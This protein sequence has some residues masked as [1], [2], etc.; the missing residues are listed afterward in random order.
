MNFRSDYEKWDCPVFIIC[1]L[2]MVVMMIFVFVNNANG[3][4]F[5]NHFKFLQGKEIV[6]INI[7]SNIP[8]QETL[9]WSIVFKLK[10]KLENLGYI[11]KNDARLYIF[12][13]REN[14]KKSLFE[15]IITFSILEEKGGGRIV[16][17]L[18]DGYSQQEVK[19]YEF[20]YGESYYKAL[21]KIWGLLR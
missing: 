15:K 3:N 17:N 5:G 16:Y 7:Y 14:R 1:L 19:I 2:A 18:S 12:N 9:A 4:N 10:E 11:N 13:S 21:D 6:V 8:G 20:I